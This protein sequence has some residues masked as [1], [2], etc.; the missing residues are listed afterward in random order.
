MA[1]QFYSYKYPEEKWKYFLQKDLYM[2]VHIYVIYNSPKEYGEN[3]N[4]Y[5][6]MDK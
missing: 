3:P 4:V 5:Q 2:N 6:L 1:Q